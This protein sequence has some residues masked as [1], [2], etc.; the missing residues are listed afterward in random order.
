[1]SFPSFA[2][3]RSLPLTDKRTVSLAGSPARPVLQGCRPAQRSSLSG[4]FRS[5]GTGERLPASGVRES[6]LTVKLNRQ[7]GNREFQ[8]YMVNFQS[9]ESSRRYHLGM[10]HGS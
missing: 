7:G 2:C 6:P 10:S 4:D 1:M 9:N 8:S 3:P 5:F